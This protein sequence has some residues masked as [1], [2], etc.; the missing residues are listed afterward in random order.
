MNGQAEASHAS[1]LWFGKRALAVALP[2]LGA[3]AAGA[4]PFLFAPGVSIFFLYVVLGVAPVAVV[5]GACVAFTA[6]RQRSTLVKTRIQVSM[7]MCLAWFAAWLLT[8]FGSV[9]LDTALSSLPSAGVISGVVVGPF[10]SPSVYWSLVAT[11][12]PVFIVLCGFTLLTVS[13][14]VP[15]H[16][17]LKRMRPPVT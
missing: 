3:A 12:T 7:V 15:R 6:L 17:A 5:I 9:L 10:D 1:R 4:I 8:P 14:V 2:I 13:V 16:T 11:S